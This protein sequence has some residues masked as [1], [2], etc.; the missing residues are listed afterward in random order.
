MGKGKT[1]LGPRNSHASP[2]QRP[3]VHRDPPRSTPM[4]DIVARAKSVA[5][6]AVT[7]QQ[8]LASMRANAEQFR[9][10]SAGDEADPHGTIRNAREEAIQSELRAAR[11][12]AAPKRKR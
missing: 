2:Y 4:A 11:A 9:P 7:H 3:V 8:A 10:G 12:K 1:S 6:H 5:G